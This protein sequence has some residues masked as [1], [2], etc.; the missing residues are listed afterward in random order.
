MQFYNRMTVPVLAQSTSQECEHSKMKDKSL[1][2]WDVFFLY[3]WQE[4]HFE[5]KTE[6]MLS[7]GEREI[8]KTRRLQN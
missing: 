8:W 6:A 3:T 1:I 5:I 7:R 2:C 4:Y